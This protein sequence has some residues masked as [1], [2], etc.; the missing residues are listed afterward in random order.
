[1]QNSVQ[2]IYVHGPLYL[3][4]VKMSLVPTPT[5]YRNI[6]MCQKPR[7]RGTKLCQINCM[8]MRIRWFIRWMYMHV[9]GFVTMRCQKP[10]D[11]SLRSSRIY[12]ISDPINQIVCK[13]TYL[14]TCV[15]SICI[16]SVPFV[17]STPRFYDPL[18]PPLAQTGLFLLSLLRIKFYYR[19]VVMK[20]FRW[21]RLIGSL[22]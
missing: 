11:S 4:L 17:T 14:C 2:N 7:R 1:M 13:F 21:R 19:G 20:W 22:S 3:T 9:T 5:T 6:L 18:P 12:A 16:G 15:R 10:W 8:E